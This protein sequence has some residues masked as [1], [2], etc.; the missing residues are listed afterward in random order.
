MQEMLDAVVI[1]SDGVKHAASGLDG[2]RRRIA[3]AD[4]ASPSWERYRPGERNPQ[5]RPFRG[6]AERARSDEDRVLQMETA[7]SDGEIDHG[8]GF[9]RFN[10]SSAR[11]YAPSRQFHCLR[12]YRQADPECAVFLN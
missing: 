2:A 3:G 1:E 5:C 9:Y 12:R 4:G 11:A 10:I 8:F 7:E 6:V